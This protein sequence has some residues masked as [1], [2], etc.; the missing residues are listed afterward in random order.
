MARGRG[1]YSRERRTGLVTMRVAFMGMGLL[2][3][4][5]YLAFAPAQGPLDAA[6]GDEPLS[7]FEADVAAPVARRRLLGEK[8]YLHDHDDDGV[9]YD[10]DTNP[11]GV[12]TCKTN[13]QVSVHGSNWQN[14]CV[15]EGAHTAPSLH[16]HDP[17]LHHTSHRLSLSLSLM[18]PG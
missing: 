6:I 4:S 9:R 17:P 16:H 12:L 11:D 10:K 2:M 3:C 7:A 14:T 1:G 13:D 15:A 18:P 5:A 8:I